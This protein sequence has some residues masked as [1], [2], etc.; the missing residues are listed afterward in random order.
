M[1]TVYNQLDDDDDVEV[2]DAAHC[3]LSHGADSRNSLKGFHSPTLVQPIHILRLP[4]DEEFIRN[5]SC[6]KLN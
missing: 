4:E 6:S 1:V 2:T 5:V 3:A